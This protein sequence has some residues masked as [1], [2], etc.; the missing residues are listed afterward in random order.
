M[1]RRTSVEEK[2][3]KEKGKCRGR[4]ECSKEMDI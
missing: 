1:N 2:E 4:V 3:K